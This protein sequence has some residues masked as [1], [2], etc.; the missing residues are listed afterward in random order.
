MTDP[1]YR[2]IKDIEG[3][4]FCT[5]CGV[6]VMER[7]THDAW[8]NSID[9]IARTAISADSAASMHRPLGGS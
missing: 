2:L 5:D 8:H 4:I 9:G 6:T 1:R 3:L 7:Q